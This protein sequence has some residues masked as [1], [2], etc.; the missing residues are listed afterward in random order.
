MQTYFCLIEASSKK[1]TKKI[2]TVKL[3]QI[4]VLY[5]W[6]VE[7]NDQRI[8]LQKDN[9]QLKLYRVRERQ[10]WAQL[11]EECSYQRRAEYVGIKALRR[12][13]PGYVPEIQGVGMWLEQNVL[14]LA[15]SLN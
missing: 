12:E 3:L 4:V 2:L 5:F 9:V 11:R 15:S 13:R 14:Y 8:L 1:Q 7:R 10:A 6:D